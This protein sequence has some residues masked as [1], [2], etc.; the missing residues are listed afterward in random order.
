MCLLAADSAL[1]CTRSIKELTR[2]LQT[3]FAS[4]T[5]PLALPPEIRRLLQQFVN[6][7]DED[8]SK[9]EASHANLELRRLW[10]EYIHEQP[11]KLPAFAGVLRELRI[12]IREADVLFWWQNV[13]RPLISGA[14]YNRVGLD[15]AKDFITAVIIGEDLTI[16][17]AAAS[18]IRSQICADLFGIYTSRALPLMDEGDDDEFLALQMQIAKQAEDVLVAFGRRRPK[19]LFHYVDDVVR[20]PDTR[21]Q[22]LMLLSSFLQHRTP[23]LYL[24]INTPLVETLLKCLLND[25]S[26]TLLTVALTCL[27]MLLP[28]IPGS[29]GSHLPKF[30]LVYSRLLCWERFDPASTPEQRVLLADKRLSSSDDDGGPGDVGTDPNWQLTHPEV[31]SEGHPPSLLTYFTYLYGLFPI[32]FTTYIRKPRRYLKDIDFSNADTFDLN[33]AVIRSR[34][35]QF[36]QLHLLHPNFYNMTIEEELVDPKWP[37]ID[38]ADVVGECQRLR[39]NFEPT[40]TSQF[41]NPPPNRKLPHPPS[42][43]PSSAPDSGNVTPS[44]SHVSLRS[45]K[46]GKEFTTALRG[47]SPILKGQAR[48][49]EDDVANQEKPDLS[50]PDGP[51]LLQQELTLLR[52]ELN[53]ERWQKTQYSEHIGQI[54]RRNLKDATA[55][56]ETYN[57]INA[58]RQLKQQVEQMRKAQEATSKDSALTR[59]QANSLETDLMDRFNKFKQEQETWR[60][61]SDELR[62]LRAEVSQYQELL[63]A[64]EARELNKSRQLQLAQQDLEQLQ[65]VQTQLQQIKEKLH[66]YEYREFEFVTAKRHNEILQAEKERLQMQIQRHEDEQTRLRRAF[67]SRVTELETQIGVGDG[68]SRTSE[69]TSGP[70]V[71][72]I[73]QQAVF[74]SQSKLTQ[75]KK[76]YSRLL[77]KHTDLELE[78]QSLKSHLEV[79]QGSNAGTS[80][81][82]PTERD[83]FSFQFIDDYR[84]ETGFE[85]VSSSDPTNRRFQ[86]QIFS[87]PTTSGS[88]Q[89]GFDSQ[90]G[91]MFSPTASGKGSIRSKTSSQTAA[92]FNP[93]AP[94]SKEETTSAFSDYSAGSSSK[95]EKIKPDSN[96]RVYG[97]GKLQDQS[98]VHPSCLIMSQVER[99]ISS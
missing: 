59:K 30:F 45:G 76:A 40:F 31:A 74:D 61:D 77:E 5:A 75:L 89:P 27:T 54:M 33:Q 90:A 26:T 37:K 32:N 79:A 50:M 7:Y 9:D 65:K 41:P 99:R 62:Q 98:V 6:E 4:A 14:N 47:E 58:N 70:D 82:S 23:H 94:L 42:R 73:V 66:E 97:R 36:R 17:S 87:P 2:A 48:T 43:H 80:F 67:A 22:A 13:A 1:R 52:S 86:P 24:V 92:A 83:S 55:E 3:Q 53:F 78:Y 44:A 57:L 19:D 71:Q 69:S 49:T 12:A 28:H 81:Y 88:G 35:E 25:T 29:M 63:V 84:S 8:A 34:T 85:N 96:V 39:T 21:L 95:K 38:P 10:E 64:T 20:L 51:A 16:E 56:A 60:A 91:I 15:D 68:R 93:S 46:G 18:D 11:Q 72:A